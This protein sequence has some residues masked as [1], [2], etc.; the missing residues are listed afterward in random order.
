MDTITKPEEPWFQHLQKF[1]DQGACAFKLDA[2]YQVNGTSGPVWGNGMC[3]EEMHNLYPAILNK[4]MSLGFE[5]YTGP[6]KHDLQL[7]RI[8]RHTA[9]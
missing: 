7:R 4:Q 1:V 3:D 8:H 5:E 6:P 2:A 9:L